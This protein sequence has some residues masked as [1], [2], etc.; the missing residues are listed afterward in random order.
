ME[1]HPSNPWSIAGAVIVVSG[2]L[3]LLL[4]MVGPWRKQISD[5]E[6]RLRGALETALKAERE[7]HVSDI[8]KVEAKRDSE[9]RQFALERDEMGDRIAALETIIKRR[10]R[11]RE[12]ERAI[13]RH[14]FNNLDACF[15][16]LLLLLKANP[17]KVS[18]AV[19]M[20]EEMRGKQ[21]LAET[22]EKAIILAA[23]ITDA[24]GE[25]EAE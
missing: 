18:E 3:S 21:L 25:G 6:E 16:A 24:G 23:E 2:L 10:D 12:A 8:L 15:N 22:E 14:R 13:E 19:A 7:A 17:D 11:V 5:A 20:I 9:A 4:R 1:A